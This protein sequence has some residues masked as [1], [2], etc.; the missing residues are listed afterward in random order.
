MMPG[1][2]RAEVDRFTGSR[3][4]LVRRFV[5]RKVI[6]STRDFHYLVGYLS[7]LD[8]GDELLRLT[9]AGRPVEV[10]RTAVVSI[11]KADPALA[12]YVK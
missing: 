5:G 8:Q 10:A 11:R 7:S 3:P 2:R 4:E 1:A 6:L 9:V 12:E